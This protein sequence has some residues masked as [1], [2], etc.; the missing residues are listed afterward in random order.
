MPDNPKTPSTLV[1]EKYKYGKTQG[2]GVFNK[3]RAGWADR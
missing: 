1:D 3:E 2:I